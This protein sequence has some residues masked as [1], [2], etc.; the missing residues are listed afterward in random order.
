M[1]L[2]LAPALVTFPVVTRPSTGRCT[3]APIARYAKR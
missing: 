2:P 1:R 3:G